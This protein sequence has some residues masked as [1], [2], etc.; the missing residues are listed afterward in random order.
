MCVC[1]SNLRRYGTAIFS[2]A[3]AVLPACEEPVRSPPS[4]QGPAPPEPSTYIYPE[5]PPVAG[6]AA[7]EELLTGYR[8]QGY[9]V[10]LD[11][12]ATWSEP[13]RRRFADVV[14]LHR[15][16]RSE[17]FQ[18]IAVTFDNP[19][20]WTSE[21]AP[22]LRSVR[23]GYPCLIVPPSAQG[24]VVA[25]LGSEWNGSVPARLIFDRGGRLAAELL[26]DASITKTD[27]RVRA[28]LSG[29]YSVPKS[30]ERPAGGRLIARARTVD[31]SKDRTLA[32]PTS[33]WSSLD[34]VEA[35]AQT[36]ARQSE[37]TIDWPNAKVAVLPFTLIGRADPEQAGK[38]LADA[39]ARILAAK[40]PG[41]VV[42]RREADALMARHN[43]SP[44][45]VEYDPSVLAGKAGWTHIITGT[46]RWR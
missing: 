11:I 36:I 26:D 30:P 16:L 45:S 15:T 31:V 25:R 42:D 8:R 38:A 14:E 40:H 23:C 17:G 19:G 4:S 10:L 5:D 6:A 18:C 9:V 44:L 32:Q 7:L 20:L 21:I 33:Q 43:L 29:A 27:E 46:L 41:S 34:D 35:M 22:F 12:W 1:K 28:I 39:V 2:W 24:D 3:F 13:S 37:I